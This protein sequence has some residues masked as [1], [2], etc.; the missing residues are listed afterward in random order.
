MQC[1]GERCLTVFVKK[2]ELNILMKDNYEPYYEHDVFSFAIHD[3]QHME[4]FVD[5]H[6]YCEQIGF[7]YCIK[8]LPYHQQPFVDYDKEFLDD[9]DHVRSDMNTCISHSFKFFRAKWQLAEWRKLRKAGIGNEDYL[10]DEEERKFQKDLNQFLESVWEMPKQVISSVLDLSKREN[11]NTLR[12]FFHQ[13]GCSILGLQN[14]PLY[15]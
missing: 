15:E 11:V 4:K 12:N 13:I 5:P 3:L 6:F 9:M 14:Y 2:E 10:N 7:F 1:K 8:K